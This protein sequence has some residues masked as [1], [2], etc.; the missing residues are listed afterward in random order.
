MKAFN[1]SSR[2]GDFIGK[3]KAISGTD[4]CYALYNR[5]FGG[6]PN[7]GEVLEVN[8]ANLGLYVLLG[9]DEGPN[10]FDHYDVTE[11]E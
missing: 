10:G 7:R 2:G 8:E 5:V 3:V 1:V 11:I 6:Y 4:A 9:N